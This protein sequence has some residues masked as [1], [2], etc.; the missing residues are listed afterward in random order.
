LDADTL[1]A[2]AERSLCGDEEAAVFAHLAECAICRQYLAAHSELDD[3]QWRNGQQ[4]NRRLPRSWSFTRSLRT[5]AAFAG[6]AAALWLLFFSH[7]QPPSVVATSRIP[8]D[9][10]PSAPPI[11]GP[12]LARGIKKPAHHSLGAPK[13]KLPAVAIR[14][15]PAQM[16]RHIGAPWG[17]DEFRK[18]STGDRLAARN[19]QR[20]LDEVTLATVAFGGKPTADRG[21]RAALAL[22]QIALKTPF[23][24]RRITLE[25]ER[26]FTLLP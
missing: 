13:L 18:L 12:I 19:C 24:D 22:N 23:G 6:A 2:F 9:Y 25:R 21:D 20:F 26:R 1:A 11:K 16:A 10:R 3:F 7:T 17:S 15:F 4:Q 14:H 8:V 5:A